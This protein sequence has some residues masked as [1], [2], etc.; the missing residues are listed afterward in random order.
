MNEADVHYFG[1]RRIGSSTGESHEILFMA[2]RCHEPEFAN[3]DTRSG[4]CVWRLAFRA[5]GW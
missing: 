2:K 3:H 5:V 4:A 1:A